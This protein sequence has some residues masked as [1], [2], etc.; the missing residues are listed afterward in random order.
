[1]VDDPAS[2][3]VDG[4]VSGAS[5]ANVV[6]TLG[7]SVDNSVTVAWEDDETVVS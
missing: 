6:S 5:G 7:F 3:V 1:M 4:E 2:E